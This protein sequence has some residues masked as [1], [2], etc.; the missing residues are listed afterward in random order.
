MGKTTSRTQGTAISKKSPVTWS[1]SLSTCNTVPKV[2]KTH[3]GSVK[4]VAAVSEA[5][6][7]SGDGE[8]PVG[9]QRSH[10]RKVSKSKVVGHKSLG[11]TPRFPPP[12]SR[13]MGGGGQCEYNSRLHHSKTSQVFA[14]GHINSHSS[15]GQLWLWGPWKSRFKILA[16]KA[17][18]GAVTKPNGFR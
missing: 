12:I 4:S 18:L 10:S 1:R 9:G 13:K 6:S 7:N 8:A 14:T 16:T 17:G 11:S 15:L 5:G 3:S 2:I